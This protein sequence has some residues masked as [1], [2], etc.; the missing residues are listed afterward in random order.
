MLLAL[1]QETAEAH[2][3]AGP[4]MIAIAMIVI[5]ILAVVWGIGFAWGRNKRD[6][7]RYCPKC[8]REVKLR[9][10]RRCAYCGEELF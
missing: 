6:K 10:A 1:S 2:W 3:L 9:D 7:K 5:V 4:Q 8:N